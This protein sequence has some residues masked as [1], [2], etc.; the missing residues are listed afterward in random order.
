MASKLT[1]FNLAILIVVCLG[2][3]PWLL[4]FLSAHELLYHPI[5]YYGADQHFQQQHQ[6]IFKSFVITLCLFM[7][8]FFGIM[9]LHG[10]IM[11]AILLSSAFYIFTSLS[12]WALG[13]FSVVA[14]LWA[15]IQNDT[16]IAPSLHIKFLD[17]KLIGFV[18]VFLCF[19]IL[20]YMGVY[21]HYQSFHWAEM[22]L[23]NAFWSYH[24]SLTTFVPRHGL[25]EVLL[26]K[27]LG[28]FFNT[29]VVVH[30]SMFIVKF[31]S[32][33]DAYIALLMLYAITKNYFFVFS[34]FLLF[35]L[36]AINP[37]IHWTPIA[38][39]FWV[40]F[41]FDEQEQRRTQWAF[42]LGILTTVIY[43]LRVD[44]GVFLLIATVCCLF[45]YSFFLKSFT[46]IGAFALGLL[47]IIVLLSVVCGFKEIKEFIEI[48]TVLPAQYNDFVWGNTV[49]SLMPGNI[50]SAKLLVTFFYLLI[51]VALA[52]KELVFQKNQKII[53]YVFLVLI[54]AAVFKILLG[55]IDSRVFWFSAVL[56][57]MPTAMYF[58]S[59]NLK[60]VFL[61]SPLLMTVLFSLPSFDKAGYLAPY[62]FIQKGIDTVKSLPKQ[63][64]SN[65]QEIQLLFKFEALIAQNKNKVTF[66][67]FSPY[68]YVYFDTKP[69]GR[70]TDAYQIY[71]FDNPAFYQQ[72][73][74][75]NIVFWY[76]Q[77]LDTIPDEKRLSHYITYLENT[78]DTIYR[79]QKI[80]IYKNKA[81]D[82]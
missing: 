38:L 21:Y 77:N 45:L 42:I 32:V 10:K 60:K 46:H 6:L 41:T 44:I 18:F 62:E 69:V 39:T 1:R 81:R 4:S 7:L 61:I 2:L 33:T 24:D 82:Q 51:A 66:L 11:S 47:T 54:M 9:R 34:Y 31:F 43:F 52:I 36:F 25:F 76:S 71:P 55:R 72:L 29:E 48:T 8:M 35:Q 56:I 12:L 49:P 40:L 26:Q 63:L 59:G 13:L 58:L 70:Y 53:P 27:I 57:S 64:A 68:A 14:F 79:D 28:V 37:F 5:A 3:W 23:F 73:A 17:V 67:T 80:T 50:I 22:S 65:S 19:N 16:F 15:Y 20:F 74:D 75:S 78:F 30:I